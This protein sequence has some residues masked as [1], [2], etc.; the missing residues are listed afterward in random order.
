MVEEVKADFIKAAFET[1]GGTQVATSLLDRTI[2]SATDQNLQN[3]HRASRDLVDRTS[4]NELRNTV[5]A[6]C[7]AGVG[8]GVGGGD[9]EVSDFLAGLGNSLVKMHQLSWDFEFAGAAFM[10]F[11]WSNAIDG[12]ASIAA[13]AERDPEAWRQLTIS[14]GKTLIGLHPIGAVINITEEVGKYAGSQLALVEAAWR[15]EVFDIYELP[16]SRTYLREQAVLATQPAP[17]GYDEHTATFDGEGRYENTHPELGAIYYT[18][19]VGEYV[20]V[21]GD[22]YEDA[23]YVYT[24]MCGVTGRSYSVVGV[25]VATPGFRDT[26]ASIRT[27][28]EENCACYG[29]AVLALLGNVAVSKDQISG[30]LADGRVNVSYEIDLAA[31]TY[32]LGQSDRPLPITPFDTARGFLQAI[33]EP[34]RPLEHFYSHLNPDLNIE[35]VITEFDLRGPNPMAVVPETCFEYDFRATCLASGGQD[36]LAWGIEMTAVEGG[37]W[38]W[39]VDDVVFV[40]GGA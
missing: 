22:S 16:R 3:F 34:G 38:G 35:T 23:V 32:R 13:L 20:D 36:A 19:Q 8:G 9:S 11:L 4:E 40:G 30:N 10:Y 27:V 5:Q 21:N 29:E 26:P 6:L 25:H 14:L 1:S 18:S 28:L 7:A 31:G 39:R 24:E 33:V 12:A 17:C 15:Y 2:L 37:V